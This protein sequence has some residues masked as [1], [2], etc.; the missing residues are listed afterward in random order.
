MCVVFIYLSEDGVKKRMEKNGQV[1]RFHVKHRQ[2]PLT[3][4]G[5]EAHKH[6]P[7]TRKTAGGM[8]HFGQLTSCLSAQAIWPKSS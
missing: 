6:H 3:L 4:T 1:H 5:I 8:T 7:T 2:P